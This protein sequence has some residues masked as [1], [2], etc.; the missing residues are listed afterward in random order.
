MSILKVSQMGHPV[1]RRA[2]D[3]VHPDQIVTDNFQRLVT[4]MQETMIAYGGAGLAAPQVHVSARLLVYQDVSDEDEADPEILTLVNPVVEPLGEETA[5]AWEGCLSIP[6]VRGLVSRYTRI[7][8]TALD[9]DGETLC[10]T[11][12]NYEARVIQHE[13]DHLDGI[14]YFDRMDDLRT[15]SF[16]T[17]YER[18]WVQDEDEEDLA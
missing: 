16:Q 1:L 6:N 8:V 12:E 11:A 7:Q 17:E 5:S 3:P 14:L 9:E 10:Y 18:F 2:A 15:L 13:V 4:D